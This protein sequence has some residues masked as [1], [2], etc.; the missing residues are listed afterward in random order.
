MNNSNKVPEVGSA[1]PDFTLPGTAGQPVTLSE[2]RGTPVLLVFYPHAFTG[3]CTDE[4]CELRDNIE[5]FEADGVQLYGISADPLP[6]LKVFHEQQ[7]YQFPLL[8]DFWPHGDV[9]RS[10]GVFD[11]DN[12][13]A[14]RGSFLLDEGGQIRWSVV[15]PRTQVRALAEYRQALAD[16][17]SGA[18]Q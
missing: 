14:V 7:Q 18:A 9:I 11:E 13:T 1:A 3:R 12:G 8:A 4:L 15:N 16:L 6:A 2:L 17:R 5:L 10:Y